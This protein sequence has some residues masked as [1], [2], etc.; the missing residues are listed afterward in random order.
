MV[1]E[2]VEVGVIRVEVVWLRLK[3]EGARATMEIISTRARAAIQI[4]FRLSLVSA[5][6]KI[7]PH[8]SLPFM[9]PLNIIL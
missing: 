9:V 6:H 7:P 5:Q 3:K 8:L 1:F 2:E 4:H